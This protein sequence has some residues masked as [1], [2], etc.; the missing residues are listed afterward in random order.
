VAWPYKSIEQQCHVLVTTQP[1]LIAQESSI[2][3]IK[4]IC[5]Y[6]QRLTAPQRLQD[7]RHA[8]SVLLCTAA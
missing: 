6:L 7:Q 8:L 1:L 5:T 2:L 3:S 4:E